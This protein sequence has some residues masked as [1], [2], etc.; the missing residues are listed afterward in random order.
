M[1][2]LTNE[3]RKWW[4]RLNQLMQKNNVTDLDGLQAVLRQLALEA[5]DA[6]PEQDKIT[7]GEGEHKQTL[8]IFG[9]RQEFPTKAKFIEHH[10]KD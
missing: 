9:E 7:V 6:Q 1:S 8:R 3:Q 2:G 10:R 4:R 5:I